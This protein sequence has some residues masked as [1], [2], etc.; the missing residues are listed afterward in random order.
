LD[1][2]NELESKNHDLSV[3]KNNL[4]SQLE[5]GISRLGRTIVTNNEESK[6]K[7]TQFTK[8]SANLERTVNKRAAQA[9]RKVTNLE[10]T[11]NKLAAQAK[12]KVTNLEGTVDGLAAENMEKSAKLEATVDEL[13][14]KNKR[15]LSVY[16]F[17][18]R[19]IPLSCESVDSIFR[20]SI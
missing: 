16:R 9:K 10:R 7:A 5:E 2:F 15:K 4:E 12:R 17:V 19:N 8:N 3:K 13:A 1:K 18:V 20:D 11:V 6:R 14:A